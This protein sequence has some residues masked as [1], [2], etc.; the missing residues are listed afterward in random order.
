M[1]NIVD[2]KLFAQLVKNG[3]ENLK[4]DKEY[5][6]ELN[7]F[8]IP[9]GDTGTNMLATLEGGVNATISL[10]ERDIGKLS[11]LMAR[12]M[13]MT[14]RGNSG[15]ITSQI[16][17]GI[18]NGL[19]DKK[20]VNAKEFAYAFTMGTKQ[21][22]AVCKN[23]TEGTI[24]T[25]VREAGEK[26]YNSVN[27]N[28]SIEEFFKYY[29][30]EAKASLKR[31]PDLLPCLK[32][33]GVV[34]SG[35]AGFIRVVEGMNMFLL[36]HVVTEENK[37]TNN[38]TFNEDSTFDVGYTFE[39][40]LQLLKSKCNIAKFDLETIKP[41]ISEYGQIDSCSINGTIVSVNMNTM[42]PGKVIN[43]LQKYGE[44]ILLDIKNELASCLPEVKNEEIKKAEHKEVAIVATSQGE[45]I[46]E[47]LEELGVDEVVTG[48]QTMNPSTEDFIKAFKKLN[49]DTI[50]V[51][52]N[53]S[54]IFMAASQAAE[55]YHDA[56]V[57][58]LN[59]KSVATCYSC[60][61]MFDLSEGVDNLIE[62]FNDIIEN[63]TYGEITYSIRDSEINGVSIKKD[64]YI[65]ILNHN[66]VASSD[67]KVSALKELLSHVDDIKY[68]EVLVLIY[69]KDVT[70]EQKEEVRSFL[71][72]TYPRLEYGEIDGKQDIYDFIISI[73]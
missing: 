16:F 39:A 72:S 71:S 15:V 61:S 27:E 19:V 50:I 3:Y 38:D 37:P 66:I 52:P 49:A 65:S 2:G 32:E 24:L 44:F 73:E 20:E 55:Q 11:K 43:V 36:G 28:S 41:L 8:P 62:S 70:E 26:A 35:A 56:K 1:T 7:V 68:K 5:I 48:G 6:N 67:D 31:T 60:M 30:L 57:V 42:F 63:N 47:V 29:L 53:N 25:V 34:D 54:N 69:G 45:G 14:A 58:V 59:S 18:A 51:F 46:S 23:P 40:K 21:A 22:Y 4:L 10:D 9:D 13:L 12:N 17:K 33:A 64:Q